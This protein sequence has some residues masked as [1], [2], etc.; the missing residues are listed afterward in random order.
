MYRSL[1]VHYHSSVRNVI[2]PFLLQVIIRN[3]TYKNEFKRLNNTPS[4]NTIVNTNEDN[5][6]SEPIVDFS[7]VY[8]TTPN[9]VVYFDVYEKNDEENE[10][11]EPNDYL[12]DEEPYI[13]FSLQ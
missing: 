3:Q 4:K 8:G 9:R 12:Q 7:L 13:D 11:E 1:K 5:D 6:N 2:S 10:V